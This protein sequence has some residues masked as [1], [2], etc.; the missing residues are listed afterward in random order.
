MIGIDANRLQGQLAFFREIDKLKQVF[1]QTLLLDGSRLEN[2]A[3][4]SWHLAMMAL[5]FKD[6]APT[7]DIDIGKVLKLVIL[8]DLV[9]IDAGD[10]YTYDDFD[11][12]EKRRKEQAGA[13]RI[14]NILPKDQADELMDLWHE[15]EAKATPE[16]LFA[17]AMDKLQPFLHNYYVDHNSWRLHDVPK[18]RVI[19]K[20]S[21]IKKGA[22]KLWDLTMQLIEEA[23]AA[24]LFADSEDKEIPKAG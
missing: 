7:P 21:I 24:G 15:Y 10:V 2:D 1:R 23:D 4:H 20:M 3:E 19:E 5:T 16:A 6:Y 22:P 17:G 8:H 11:P 18:A 14:F 9:E 12:E 13:D